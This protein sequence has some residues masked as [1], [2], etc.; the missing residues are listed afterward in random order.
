MNP[1]SNILAT[2]KKEIKRKLKELQL[3]REI[4]KRINSL[5]IHNYA[6][7]FLNNEV[8]ISARRDKRAL[9][10]SVFNGSLIGG[11]NKP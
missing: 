2:R 4:D 7:S 9:A 6:C 8:K 3:E 10:N 5:S 11:R 1:Q